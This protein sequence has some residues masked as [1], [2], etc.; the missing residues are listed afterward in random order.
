MVSELIG[1]TQPCQRN[2]LIVEV[3]ALIVLDGSLEAIIQWVRRLNKTAL[4]SSNLPA[5][6]RSLFV[7]FANRSLSIS[8]NFGHLLWS[9]G[10]RE[11]HQD[12]AWERIL[13]WSQIVER[14]EL[15]FDKV[16]FRIIFSLLIRRPDKSAK[17]WKILLTVERL[18]ASPLKIKMSSAKVKW[19]TPKLEAG[20]YKD[21]LMTS[22]SKQNCYTFHHQGKEIRG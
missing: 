14:V 1:W 6:E 18:E 15:Y 19:E 10:R 17:E 4:T 8:R 5:I 9:S 11:G 21:P 7:Q 22:M 2:L 12:I 3:K 20:I 16:C 13:P